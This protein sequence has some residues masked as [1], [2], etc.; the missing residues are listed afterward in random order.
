M[1]LYIADAKFVKSGTYKD[2]RSWELFHITDAKGNRFST[3]EKK[4]TGLVGQEVE[5]EIKE[6]TVTKGGRTYTN[7][8][9]VE[10]RQQR[11]TANGTDKELHKKVDYIIELLEGMQFEKGMKESTPPLGDLKDLPF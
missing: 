8:T 4:Y 7:R 1:K 3:F 2:G 5:C 6:E 9:I 11:G 10:P